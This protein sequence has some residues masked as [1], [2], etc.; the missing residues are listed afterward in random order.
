MATLSGKH[1]GDK[2]VSQKRFF[3][4]LLKYFRLAGLKNVAEAFSE[5]YFIANLSANFLGPGKH[6]LIPLYVYR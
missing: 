6:I 4:A 3:N 5:K 1:D 2:S